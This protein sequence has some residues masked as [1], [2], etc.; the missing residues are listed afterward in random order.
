MFLKYIVSGFLGLGL[1]SVTACN[2]KPEI[3]VE[4]YKQGI[5][6]ALNA[7][8]LEEDALSVPKLGGR[9][10]ALPGRLGIVDSA[11]HDP[12]SMIVLSRKLSQT[13]PATSPA[14]YFSQQL[15]LYGLT[16]QPP[17]SDELALPT[18]RELWGQLVRFSSKGDK[19]TKKMPEEW[20]HLDDPNAPL[21][22]A[23][24]QLLYAEIKAEEAYRAAGFQPLHEEWQ[25]IRAHLTG[26]IRDK[27]PTSGDKRWL[28]PKTYHQMGARIDL[29]RMASAL[30]QLQAAV[31][32]AMPDLQLAATAASPVQL[33]IMWDTPLG[34]VKLAGTG[35]DR[36][37]GDYLLLIDLGG[38]DV[39]EN[40]GA[41]VTR[42]ENSRKHVSVVIDISGDDKV[43][44][45][46]TPGSGAGVMG[47]AVWADMA[48]NDHYEGGNVGLG[49]GLFGAGLFW[50]ASGDDRYMAGS[51]AQGAGG[52]GLGLFIDG[53]GADTYKGA[54]AGQ[55]FGS[56]GGIGILVD[57]EGNDSY[58]CG[59]VV[60]DQD[61]GRN[62]RHDVV[63]YLSMCQGFGF[64]LRPE[65][66]GGVGA[67]IDLNGNDSY[68]AD[69]F[70]QGS[71]YWFGLGMLVDR[72]GDDRYD[73]FEHCQ[74]EGVHLAAGI[75]ADFAGNDEYVG[76]EHAQ[77]TGIDRAAGVLYD[78]AGDDRYRAH[79]D[80]QG[81]GL[82]PY[83]VG[84][85]IDET[86][87]DR[88][89]SVMSS[90]G[91]AATASGSEGFPEGQWPVG[92]LLDRDGKNTF[93][94]PSIPPAVSQGRIQNLHG[95][96]VAK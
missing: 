59:E 36:H 75:L 13:N 26:V 57:V 67:L 94:Q 68:R 53:A 52:Y 42:L 69:I 81:A 8:G 51:L 25:A 15:G 62:L 56:S 90:Q 55:G 35:P 48:G 43:S 22:R 85:L 50:D 60:R 29:S 74:G 79:L 11:M 73:C 44:W 33:P 71:A 66:S 7:V 78:A 76:Y 17:V 40:V 16:I 46:K 9:Q 58:S 5:K 91:Y 45:T 28:T 12:L 63:H 30:L 77:G 65:A 87:N 93:L 64:G 84:I 34:R 61:E 70:A 1:L 86:G 19:P 2:Q 24:R 89:E 38:N 47:L 95:I 18:A 4:P 10:I 14:A 41:D 3:S 72:S 54:L 88:Y 49:A 32:R 31:E 82:K 80:S 39:Y 92:I 83:G 21:F 96:A 20:N 23:L 37:E 6:Q 27:E